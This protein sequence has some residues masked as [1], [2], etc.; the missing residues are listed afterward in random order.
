MGFLVWR[1]VEPDAFTCTDGSRKL[2]RCLLKGEN[3]AFF[4]RSVGRGRFGS[5]ASEVNFGFD[6]LSLVQEFLQ[7]NS[8]LLR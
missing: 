5:S 6:P 2:G 8:S 1:W 7:G 3:F 4:D